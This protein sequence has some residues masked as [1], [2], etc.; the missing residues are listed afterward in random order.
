MVISVQ[1]VR[2]DKLSLLLQSGNS[3]FVVLGRSA[4]SARKHT[5]SDFLKVNPTIH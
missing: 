5:V 2:F 1:L 4:R 3:G